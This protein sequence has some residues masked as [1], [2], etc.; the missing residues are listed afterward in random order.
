[1]KLITV[2]GVQKTV[3]DVVDAILNRKDDKG[4]KRLVSEG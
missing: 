3:K 4:K 1:M 2:K